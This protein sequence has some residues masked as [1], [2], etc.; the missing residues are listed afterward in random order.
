VRLTRSSRCHQ[1]VD[2]SRV[3]TTCG[4]SPVSAMGTQWKGKLQIG[5]VLVTARVKDEL[6]SCVA[7][8]R[9]CGRDRSA[10]YG[11]HLPRLR[12]RA[13]HPWR[14]RNRG[15]DGALAVLALARSGRPRPRPRARSG[16]AMS[17]RTQSLNG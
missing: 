16:W 15:R 12:K 13:R 2:K 3:E 1:F 4:V 17:A 8:L 14:Q 7:P 11:L 10:R 9:S 6:G 5:A